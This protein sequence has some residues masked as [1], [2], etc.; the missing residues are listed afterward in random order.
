ME[1]NMTETMTQNMNMNVT[2]IVLLTPPMQHYGYY[3]PVRPVLFDFYAAFHAAAAS[4]GQRAVLVANTSPRINV[5]AGSWHERL[6]RGVPES[7]LLRGFLDDIWVRDFFPTQ[8]RADY[9]ARFGYAPA[10]LDRGAVSYI[11]ASTDRAVERWFGGDDLPDGLVVDHADLVL[12]GGGIV[13]DPS[14][15][16]AIVTERVLRDNPRLV[17]RS[18]GGLGPAARCCPADPYGL[19][20]VA[21]EGTD[22]GEGADEGADPYGNFTAA[23][24]SQG[25]RNLARELGLRAVAIVPE[26]PGAPRLGHV[27]GIANFLAPNVV[28]LSAFADD[29]VYARYERIILDAFAFA[30]GDS[31]NAT[32]TVTPFPYAPTA[33]VWDVDG[34]E[35]AKGIYVNFLRTQYAT[36]V[37]TFGLPEHDA[38]ALRIA[39]AYG[40]V[41]AVAVDAGAVAILGGS[42][43][44]LSQHLWDAPADVV[45]AR[46]LASTT[47]RSASSSSSAAAAA[48]SLHEASLVSG[49]RGICWAA[50]GIA[51]MLFVFH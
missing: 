45:V 1:Q 25:R 28:A 34:F 32:V 3:D 20:P 30:D 35:S 2:S 40:D 21:G 51:A 44:C 13:F 50:V 42:V 27:D 8:L 11:A 12:D 17:G 24:L 36:Y 18:G 41:P 14:S 38:E 22:S 33:E 7:D 43:R 39:S 19:L 15:G 46:A 49:T 5:D 16:L 37:P 29:A 48:S 4:V 9:V 10:Y 6:E 23:E 31:T 47:V 26:E